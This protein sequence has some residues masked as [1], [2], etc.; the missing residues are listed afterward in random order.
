MR[1]FE[2][3]ENSAVSLDDPAEPSA[4]NPD[5]IRKNQDPD[6]WKKRPKTGVKVEKNIIFHILHS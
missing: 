6:P 1:I 5:P 4:D 3:Q 2:Y